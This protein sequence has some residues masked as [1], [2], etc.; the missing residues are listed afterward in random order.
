MQVSAII[1]AYNEAQSIGTTILALQKIAEVE[2]ILVI[3]DGSSDLTA[4]Q[5]LLAGASVRQLPHNLGKGGAL[6]EGVRLAQGKILCFVDADLGESAKEFTYLLQ[7]VLRDEADMTIA[8]FP[9][10]R[11]R[12]GLGLVKGLAI[13]GIR[14]LCGYHPL[15]PLCGQR[16]LRREV[17]DNLRT[18]LAGFGVEV[19]LTVECLRNGYRLQE[20]PVQMTHRET[21]RDLS[22]FRHR[23]KQFLHLLRTLQQ[24]WSNR[25]VKA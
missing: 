13:Y 15:S 2:E 12:G 4:V 8:I 20:I 6:Q 1:P 21:G 9:P 11:R 25:D 19:G 23:G 24:L 18:P 14:K 7:P 17:W 3:D 16:V 10:A 5:A 22:G